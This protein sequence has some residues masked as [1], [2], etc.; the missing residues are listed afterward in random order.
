MNKDPKEILIQILNIV[1]YKEDKNV[2]AERFIVLCQQQA[3][4][5]FI[6]SLPRSLQED[7]KAKIINEK[8]KVKIKQ[9]MENYV[10]TK[11]FLDKLELVTARNFK[12]YIEAIIPTLTSEQKN[13]LQ[14]FLSSL[15]A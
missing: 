12:E 14:K 6:E 5:E 9:A 8:D 11:E 4:V 3:F 10:E 7:L 15:T 1:G 2:F 13:N